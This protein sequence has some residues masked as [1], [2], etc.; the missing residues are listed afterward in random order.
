MH[1][2]SYLCSQKLACYNVYICYVAH[3]RITWAQMVHECDSLPPESCQN[4]ILENVGYLS[5]VL[6]EMSVGMDTFVMVS[7]FTSYLV[8]IQ[9]TLLIKDVFYKC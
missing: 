7:T 1:A 5:M 3:M 2:I 4:L 8:S 9:V 6:S